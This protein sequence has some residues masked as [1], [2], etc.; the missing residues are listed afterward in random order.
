[1]TTKRHQIVVQGITVEVVRKD[2]KNLHLG[3]YPPNGRVRVS[4]PSRLDDESVRLAVI[5]RLGWIRKQQDKF[6]Q[7]ARQSQREMVTGESHYFQGHRYRLNVIYCKGPSSVSI[8]KNSTLELRVR[9]GTKRD[10]REV[11]LNRWYRQQLS[12]QIPELIAKWAPTVGVTVAE[13]RIKRMKT[14]WGTCNTKAKRIWLNLEL[15]KKPDSCLEYI[16]V[17][18]IV[19]LLERQHNERFREYMNRFMPQWHIYRDELKQVPLAH[20]HWIY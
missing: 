10:K 2:I 19:H 4:V 5:S 15:A 11:I 7:Q 13:W 1:M 6:E 12:E 9:P 8:T 3:V 16:V 18:E 20:E 17:H 14:R